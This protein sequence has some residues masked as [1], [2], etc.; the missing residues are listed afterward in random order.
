MQEIEQKPA[1]PPPAQP[2]ARKASP[3]A[4]TAA[5]AQRHAKTAPTPERKLDDDEVLEPSYR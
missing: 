2:V 4:P 1:P 3:P 5:P